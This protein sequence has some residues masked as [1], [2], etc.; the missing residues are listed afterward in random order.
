MYIKELTLLKESKKNC[1]EYLLLN[2]L[3]VCGGGLSGR[4]MC[5]RE[6]K[7]SLNIVS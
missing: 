3:S 1:S 6:R 5:W 4:E 2:I 7:N